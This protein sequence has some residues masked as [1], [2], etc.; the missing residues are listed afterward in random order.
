MLNIDFPHSFSRNLLDIKK[1]TQ[2]FSP[3]GKWK[4]KKQGVKNQIKIKKDI[5]QQKEATILELLSGSNY[6]AIY[7]KLNPAID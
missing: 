5:P 7:S 6:C 4:Q 3:S 2:I 1:S